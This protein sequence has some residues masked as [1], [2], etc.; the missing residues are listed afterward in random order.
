M[1]CQGS[2]FFLFFFSAAGSFFV[3]SQSTLIFG[4]SRANVGATSMRAGKV[5][6]VGEVGW[7]EMAEWEG[8][9]G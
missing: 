5:G 4:P 1:F 8:M 6:E 7:G 9:V 2:F 3:D